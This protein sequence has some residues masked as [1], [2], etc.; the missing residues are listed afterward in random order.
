[1]LTF[2]SENEYFEFFNKHKANFESSSQL[3]KHKRGREFNY[4]SKDGIIRAQILRNCGGK[5]FLIDKGYSD[6]TN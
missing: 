3:T 4:K 2:V 5:K 6:E 1:M